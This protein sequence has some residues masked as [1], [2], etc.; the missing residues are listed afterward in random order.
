MVKI[1]IGPQCVLG[2]LCL[3]LF[4][5]VGMLFSNISIW[6]FKCCK[7]EGRQVITIL[8]GK[9]NGRILFTSTSSLTN[10]CYLLAVT[11][12]GLENGRGQHFQARGHSFSLYGPTLSRQI[13]YLF[14]AMN[15]L[16]SEFTQL[17]H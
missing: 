2:V 17:C 3:V 7:C 8:E 9:M 4:L 10:I 1:K 14:P 11:C 15:W 12:R 13:T 5:S 16:V 6:E